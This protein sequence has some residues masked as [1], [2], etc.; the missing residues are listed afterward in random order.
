MDVFKFAG[1]STHNGKT[2][3]RATNRDG[4]AEILIKEGKTGVNIQTLPQPMDKVAAKG[5]LIT[6]PEFQTPEILAALDA[7][8]LATQVKTSRGPKVPKG[9]KA[10][11]GPKGVQVAKPDND[12]PAV[13]TDEEIER[14][15]EKNMA[16][17]KQVA[18]KRKK[19]ANLIAEVTAEV[20]TV[21]EDGE[22]VRDFLPKFLQKGME[23]S[24]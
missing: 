17:L 1:V 18:N 3:F 6:L 4:Y 21:D 19:E 12:Q 22:N 24:E 14:I 8:D 23:A 7:G 10:E 9:P 11:K 15:R 13:K 5:Y 16:V 2:K 20:T